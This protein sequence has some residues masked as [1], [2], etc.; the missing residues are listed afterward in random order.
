MSRGDPSVASA[1][2]ADTGITVDRPFNPFD[3]AVALF[4]CHPRDCVRMAQRVYDSDT[5]LG[6]A[7]VREN[8][9]KADRLD[10]DGMC[11]VADAV[12]MG[13][14]VE[15]VG[16]RGSVM[17]DAKALMEC[18]MPCALAGAKICGRMDFPT[19]FGRSSTLTKNRRTV[20]DA[21]KRALSSS[22]IFATEIL[23]FAYKLAVAPLARKDGS[24]AVREVA[25]RMASMRLNRGDWDTIL[26]IGE[27]HPTMVLATVK[28]ALTREMNKGG[29]PRSA[30]V[31]RK[32]PSASSSSSRKVVS[33]VPPRP[34]KRQRVE[35]DSDSNSNSNSEKEESEKE[36]DQ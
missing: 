32:A 12:S 5:A 3:S 20:G 11:D 7:L 24:S 18:A 26:E 21:A 27:M 17:P 13:D 30:A 16:R 31:K 28:A 2:S 33:V 15:F 34:T 29:R 14:V 25:S 10:P 4:G 22:M 35:S 8:Y 19:D 9:P 6:P 23:P 1:K 36:D